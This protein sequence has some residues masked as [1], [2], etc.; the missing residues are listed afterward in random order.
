MKL[1][2]S[3]SEKPL[4]SFR[5]SNLLDSRRRYRPTRKKS[6]LLSVAFVFNDHRQMDTYN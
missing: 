4:K 2:S 6:T 3:Q 5:G 1:E